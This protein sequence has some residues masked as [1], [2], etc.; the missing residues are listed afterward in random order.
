MKEQI[1]CDHMWSYSIPYR[2]S[3]SDGI[4]HVQV[5]ATCDRCGEER[6]TDYSWDI[7]EYYTL[8]IDGEQ[9]VS[10]TCDQ[11]QTTT[12]SLDG[13]ITDEDFEDTHFC[14]QKCHDKYWGVKKN[15]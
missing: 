10:Y 8:V 15:E 9:E 12:D 7:N 2:P 4:V 1:E 11:C 6:R 14:S 5:E 13:W 3:D